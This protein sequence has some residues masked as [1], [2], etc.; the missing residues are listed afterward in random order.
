MAR[1]IHY[2]FFIEV[3]DLGLRCF[4]RL[5][6]FYSGIPIPIL[7]MQGSSRERFS[8]KAFTE[9]KPFGKPINISINMCLHD[10]VGTWGYQLINQPTKRR[11]TPILKVCTLK[12]YIIIYDKTG[13]KMSGNTEFTAGNLYS[14]HH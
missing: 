8:E 7:P 3:S 1:R 5:P 4:Q 12:L 6:S 11:I 14:K 10:T 9:Y 2:T 13:F